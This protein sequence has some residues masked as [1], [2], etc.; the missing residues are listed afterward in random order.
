MTATYYYKTGDR[1]PTMRHTLRDGDDAPI[2]LTGATVTLRM[3]RD[4]AA[5]LVLTDVAVTVIDA[6]NGIVD[7]AWG[8]NDLALAGRYLV[9]YGASIAGL[10]M[11]IPG[12]G[13]AIVLVEDQL[14]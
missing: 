8:P 12:Q 5:G 11:T 13:T 14:A 2:N 4:G 6:V 1:L 10:P 9:T 7:Y 3:K